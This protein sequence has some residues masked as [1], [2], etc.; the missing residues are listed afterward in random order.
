MMAEREAN[1]RYV[2]NFMSE[3]VGKEFD[4]I[5][6]TIT[7]FGFFVEIRDNG[8]QGLVPLRTLGGDFYLFDKEKQRLVG[9]SSGEVF[10]MG[11][12]VR[13]LLVEANTLTG[14]LQFAIS[15]RAM[16]GITG[17]ERARKDGRGKGDFKRRTGSVDSR[18]RD[19]QRHPRPAGDTQQPQDRKMPKE[20][21]ARWED[22]EPRAA[23]SGEKPGEPRSGHRKG[24][25]GGG[26]KRFG[27]GGGGGQGGGGKPKFGGGK[28]FGGG[29]KG[30]R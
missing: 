19:A 15:G 12:K 9:R 21:S 17:G 11:Q 22:Y 27:G 20:R 2:A 6:A 23:G 1:E 29:N 25:S 4:A 10:S 26:K 16:R 18:D 5:I 3:Q 24:G 14:S 8:V 30:K 28:K 7:S 13:V